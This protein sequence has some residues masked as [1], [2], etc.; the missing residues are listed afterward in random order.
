MKKILYILTFFTFISFSAFSQDDDGTI[1]ERMANYISEK[2]YLSKAEK[3]KFT[4]LYMDYLKELRKTSSDNREDK[5]VMQQ[6]I[7]DLRLRYRESFKS[8]MG[9]KKAND[10]Y[11]H[12]KTFMREAMELRRERMQKRGG[13]KRKIDKLQ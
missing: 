12:E 10:V 9:E 4:P 8:I 11:L 7:V 5:L 6:K 2:L 13:L 1:P 3:D